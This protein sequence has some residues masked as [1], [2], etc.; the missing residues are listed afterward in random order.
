MLSVCPHYLSSLVD[1][2][3]S[4]KRP[5]TKTVV[6]MATITYLWD[7]TEEFRMVKRI[8]YDLALVLCLRCRLF[9]IEMIA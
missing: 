3:T 6:T 4:K 8:K 9:L 1:S 7:I 5:V 2:K